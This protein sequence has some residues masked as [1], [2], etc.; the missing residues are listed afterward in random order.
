MSNLTT[1]SVVETRYFL[2]YLTNF[3]LRL[4][5]D[6]E[7]GKFFSKEN[8]N[9]EYANE[10][11]ISIVITTEHHYLHPSWL[12]CWWLVIF[13]YAATNIST[14][15]SLRIAFKSHSL[16]ALEL[17]IWG[18]LKSSLYWGEHVKHTRKFVRY[19]WTCKLWFYLVWVKCLY[20]LNY[21]IAK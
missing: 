5:L 13:V 17:K 9:I 12:S 6:N 21:F 1:V 4:Y 10:I 16:T 2:L 19:L 15:S 3:K 7:T 8:K 18:K 14:A 11:T 20:K